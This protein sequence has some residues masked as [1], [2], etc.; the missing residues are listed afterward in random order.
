M[1]PNQVLEKTQKF[2]TISN[3]NSIIFIGDSKDNLVFKYDFLENKYH[4]LTLESNKK[5][6]DIA[7]MNLNNMNNTN[8]LGNFKYA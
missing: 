1:K 8:I 7:A 5:D 4:N 2:P 6:A 3:L